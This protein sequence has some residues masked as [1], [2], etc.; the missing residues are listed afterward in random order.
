MPG[1]IK[2]NVSGPAAHIVHAVQSPD[3]EY[4]FKDAEQEKS[5]EPPHELEPS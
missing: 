3:L 5:T 2:E 1:S 4:S